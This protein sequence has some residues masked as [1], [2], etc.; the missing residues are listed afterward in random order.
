MYQLEHPKK[1]KKQFPM[2]IYDNL[3]VYDDMF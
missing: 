3:R 1:K 2:I